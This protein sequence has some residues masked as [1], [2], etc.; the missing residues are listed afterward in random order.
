VDRTPSGRALGR[1]GVALSLL[2]VTTMVGVAVVGPSEVNLHPIGPGPRRWLSLTFPYGAST[3]VLAVAVVLG[4][5]GLL[6]GWLSLRRGWA[7]D[8]RPL[9]AAGVASAVV[10]AVVPPLASSDIGIYA[11]YGR[12]VRLGLNPFTH[13]VL[14]LVA[15]GDLV[16]R[17]YTGP[18]TEVSSVYGPVAMAWDWL[19]ALI[20]GDSARWIVWLLQLTAAGLFVAIAVLLDRRARA[21]GVSARV[22][23]A[24]LWTL[25]PLLMLQL[26]N[27]AHVDVLGIVLGV[28]ALLLVRRTP[29]TSGALAGL[30]VAVKITFGLYAAA[31]LWA[32]RRERRALV[33][34]AVTFGVTGLVLFVPVMPE[35]LHPL[36]EGTRRVT[37]VSIWHLVELIL[38]PPLGI[39]ATDLVITAGSTLLLVLVAWRAA[40]ALPGESAERSAA[41]VRTAALLSLAWLLTSTYAL[42]WYDGF[43]WAPLVLLPASGL[44]LVALARLA[45]ITLACLPG[46]T[47]PHGTLGTINETFR[48]VVATSVAW[49]LVILVLLAGRRLRLPPPTGTP[50]TSPPP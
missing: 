38:R 9:M 11:A 47:V 44:D 30:A 10:L 27:G 45:V 13:N 42:P 8:P 18:W 37:G 33:R 32:L 50:A 2:S 26:V 39:P 36:R 25:N 49:L 28:S 7:P 35:V 31:L 1:I 20:G 14:D 4:A 16:G 12:M 6:L 17:A 15:R 21:D 3:A 41:A 23:V 48:A 34:W 29:V 40:P 5:T 22:R 46:A 43:A 24:L 19:A